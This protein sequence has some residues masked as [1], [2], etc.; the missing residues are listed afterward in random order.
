[1]MRILNRFLL[2][3]CVLTLQLPAT[4]QENAEPAKAASAGETVADDTTAPAPTAVEDKTRKNAEATVKTPA[5]YN[6]T[7]EISDDLS[8]SFPVDI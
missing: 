8:V 4:A 2:L 7:E 3:T 6:P 1:M 5:S